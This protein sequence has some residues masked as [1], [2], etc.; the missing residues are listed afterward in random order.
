MGQSAEELRQSIAETRGQLGDKVDAISDQV[1]PGRIVERQKDKVRSRWASARESL[2]GG[3]TDSRSSVAGVG[4][5][6]SNAPQSAVQQAQGRPLATG[7]VAFG[8]GFLAA[9]VF[10]GSRTEGEFAQ[11]LQDVAQPTIDQIKASGQDAVSA[12]REPAQD[13]AQQLKDTATTAAAQVSGTARDAAGDTKDAATQAG[14][15]VTDQAQQ[16]A[17]KVKGS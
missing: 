7:A 8:L 13:A 1:S 11:K 15:T 14:Q 3:A 17:E 12:L 16:S 6:V 10:P 2:M 4:E 9:A 5:A